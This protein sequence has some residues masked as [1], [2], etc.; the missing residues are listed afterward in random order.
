MAAS[1]LSVQANSRPNSLLRSHVHDTDMERHIIV[2]SIAWRKTPRTSALS[3]RFSVSGALNILTSGPPE[4]IYVP[5]TPVARKLTERL[6]KLSLEKAMNSMTD[7]KSTHGELY[8]QNRML[9]KS[10]P[11]SLRNTKASVS[12]AAIRT[13]TMIP[14]RDADLK[15]GLSLHTRRNLCHYIDIYE[16]DIVISIRIDETPEIAEIQ[17]HDRQQYHGNA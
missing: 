5:K 9:P 8:D 14:K 12:T 10:Y 4:R 7:A 17:V 13:Q 3:Y 1:S 6:L 15:T 16:I 2:T 11:L